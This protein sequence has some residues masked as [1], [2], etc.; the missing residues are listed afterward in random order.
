VV[1]LLLW[2]DAFVST[3]CAL[4]AVASLLVLRWVHRARI[5]DPSSWPPQ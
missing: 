5:A 3:W 2:Q 1:C 4:A